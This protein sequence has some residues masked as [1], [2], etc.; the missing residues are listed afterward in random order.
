MLAEN[1][2][3]LNLF[4]LCLLPPLVIIV[5]KKRG[6]VGKKMNLDI[7]AWAI[8]ILA[9]EEVSVRTRKQ[10]TGEVRYIFTKRICQCL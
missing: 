3:A 6:G 9:W 2:T 1:S 4:L 7:L 10:I 5:N 8:Q